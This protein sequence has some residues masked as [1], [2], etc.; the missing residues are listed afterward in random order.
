M[1]MTLAAA[2]ILAFTASGAFAA[3]PVELTDA[4]M[5]GVT[6]GLVTV[7]A[8]DVVDINNNTVAVPVQATI[9]VAANV[10]AIAICGQNARNQGLVRQLTNQ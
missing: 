6:A 7:V 4:Q 2:A 8:F 9:P 10:C 5:D 3:E 1:K